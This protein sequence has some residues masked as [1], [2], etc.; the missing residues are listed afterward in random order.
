[1]IK[2]IDIK[3]I[4]EIIEKLIILDTSQENY[5]EKFF[6]ERKELLERIIKLL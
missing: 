5:E 1:M 2:H 4:A 3:H 6:E